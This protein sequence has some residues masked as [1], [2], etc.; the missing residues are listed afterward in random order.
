[1]NTPPIVVAQ[2]LTPLTVTGPKPGLLVY[3]LGENFSGWPKIVVR[4]PAGRKVKLIPGELLDKDGLVTQHSANARPGNEVS[5]SYILQGGGDET[6]SPRFTY[7]GF[8]YVQ[9]EGATDD[10]VFV[11]LR[12]EFLH[13]D[14]PQVGS[15]DCS[16]PLLVRVH[17]LIRRALLSNT[18]SVLTDCP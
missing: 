8:R 6:W 5:F 12:G 10:V 7:Y 2:T 11:S 1:Q 18:M 9:V 14:L 4:G 15:F 13:A 17:G 16:N 3:D